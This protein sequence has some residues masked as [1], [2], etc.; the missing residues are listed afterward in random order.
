MKKGW[1]PALFLM[2][3]C[4]FAFKFSDDINFAYIN[5]VFVIVNVGSNP[6][7]FGDFQQFGDY[8]E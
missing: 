8:W 5:N 7:A 4:L 1:F 6:V 2:L 3:F